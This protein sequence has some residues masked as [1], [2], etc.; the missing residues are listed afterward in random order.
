MPNSKKGLNPK[1]YYSLQ[2][3]LNKIKA[4]ATA[5]FGKLATLGDAAEFMR[6]FFF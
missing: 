3:G 6:P 5:I 2:K 1:E 4:M